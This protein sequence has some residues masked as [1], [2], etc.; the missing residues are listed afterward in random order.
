MKQDYNR[1]RQELTVEIRK[2]E[3][4]NIFKKRRQINSVEKEQGESMEV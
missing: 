4:N 1:N 3:R 2:E